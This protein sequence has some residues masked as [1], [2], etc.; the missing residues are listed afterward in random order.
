MSKNVEQ[1]LAWDGMESQENIFSMP[2]KIHVKDKKKLE[3]LIIS[4][5]SFNGS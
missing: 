5:N 2:P 1:R 4:K 3:C